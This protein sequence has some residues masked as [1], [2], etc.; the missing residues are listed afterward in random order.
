MIEETGTVVAL[1]AEGRVWVSTVRQSACGGCQS[2]SACDRGLL[3]APSRASARVLARSDGWSLQ[4]GDAVV[5][6]VEAAW[7]W[8]GL[9][10]L[11]VTP[12]LLLTAGGLTGQALSG[13]P[14]AVAGAV[15][16]LAAGLGLARFLGDERRQN[17]Y[18]PIVIK[19][20]RP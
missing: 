7:L 16:G 15:A 3:S 5:L 19:K 8:R 9:L 10:L 2:A 13:E 11:Y 14:G 20:I 1:E 18:L 17:K 12:L 4:T 6:G